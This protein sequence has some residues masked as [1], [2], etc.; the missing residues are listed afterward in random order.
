MQPMLWQSQNRIRMALKVNFLA[1]FGKNCRAPRGGR[2]GKEE[3]DLCFQL[4]KLFADS[5]RFVI[6]NIAVGDVASF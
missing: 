5:R 4:M 3:T 2:G 1:L 6:V